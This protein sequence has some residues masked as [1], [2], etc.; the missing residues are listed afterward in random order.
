MKNNLAW[1]Y[2]QA[3]RSGIFCRKCTQIVTFFISKC[4]YT[5]QT[6]KN[7]DY[8]CSFALKTRILNSCYDFNPILFWKT[9]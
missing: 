5:D 6:L 1:F 7:K 9:F 3:K 2:K 8:T 4:I